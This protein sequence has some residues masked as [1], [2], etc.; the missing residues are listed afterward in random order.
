MNIYVNVAFI[1]LMLKV[2]VCFILVNRKIFI[3][4]Y[5]NDYAE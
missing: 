3:C 4:D 2:L 5:N 1:L